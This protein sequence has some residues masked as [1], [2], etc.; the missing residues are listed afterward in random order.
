MAF[1]P[2]PLTPAQEEVVALLGSPR[3]E[4]P[5]F[6]PALRTR[7]RDE[8]EDALADLAG[9]VEPLTV[10]KR[11]LAQVH[12]CELRFAAEAV[13]PFVVSAPIAR[14]AVAHKAIELSVNWRGEPSPGELVDEALG[15]LTEDERWLSEWLRTASDAERAELRGQ[16]NDLVVK[17]LDC[18]PPLRARWR[19]ATESP[20]ISELVGGRVVLRGKVD[21]TLGMPEGRQ[22]GRVII[23]FKSGRSHPSHLEDLRFYA[24]LETLQLGVPPRRLASYYLDQGRPVVEDVSEALLEAA[25]ARTVDGV[26]KIAELLDG[27]APQPCA[28]PRCRWCRPAADP[29]GDHESGA[30]DGLDDGW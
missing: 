29:S 18:F 8:L 4:R 26:R 24:L 11:H 13:A 14:G 22:A 30:T 16:A 19:P 6:D 21:L 2:R 10:T 9:R 3:A 12:G 20:R 27:R 1:E 25:T 7:L 23:D 17:F 5:E 28:S 15:R